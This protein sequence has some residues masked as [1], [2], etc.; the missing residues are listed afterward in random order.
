MKGQ[1]VVFEDVGKAALRE[2]ELPQPTPR[3][4]V[5]TTLVSGVSVGTERWAYIGKR[6]EIRFPNVPGYMAIARVTEVGSEAKARG[7]VPGQLINFSRARMPEPYADHSWMAS[8]VSHAV[9]DV[10]VPEWDPEG[11][12]GMQVERVPEGLDEMQASLTQLASVA[13]RGIE[14]AN[15]PMGASVLVC[16]LGVIGLYAVQICRLKGALIAAT[17]VVPAR[18]DVARKYGA[19]WVIDGKNEDLKARSA[20]IAPKGFDV[21]IDTS[22]IPAVVNRLFPLLKQWGKFVFQGWYAPPSPFDF[23]ALHMRLPTCYVPCGHTGRGTAAAMRWAA[24]GLLDTKSMITHV[25]GPQEAKGI[26][27]MLAKG[28]EESL[29]VVFDWRKA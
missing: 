16:G 3:D 7:Y 5:A 21:I 17:D 27:E 24:E 19:Q 6:A 1:A 26:Y 4:V 20:E 23:N 29:G 18:L 28:A 10:C 25:S 12:N 22:S 13:L 14:M 9:V 15:I 2:F 8:H 11:F